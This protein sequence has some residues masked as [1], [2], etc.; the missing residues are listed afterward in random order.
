MKNSSAKS[1]TTAALLVIVAFFCAALWGSVPAAAQSAELDALFTELSRPKQPDWK[2]IEKKINAAWRKSGS[3]AMDQLLQRGQEALNAGE[4]LKSVD[5]FT[6][7]TDHAP[8]FSQGWYAR[9][10]AFYQ[11]EEYGLAISDLAQALALNPR[12]FGA[13]SGLGIILEQL[14]RPKD[15]LAAYEQAQALHPHRPKVNEAVERLKATLD[16]AAL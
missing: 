5:H 6:A 2:A 1:Q 13:F 7:L 14:D 9:S 15:A 11:M 8:D 12:H 16:G 3:A 4:V 10:K